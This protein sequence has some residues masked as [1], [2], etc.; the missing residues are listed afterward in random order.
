MASI[1][2]VRKDFRNEALRLI[3]AGDGSIQN[4][5]ETA[6][7]HFGHL[8]GYEVLI[9]T[10]LHNEVGNAMSHLRNDGCVETVGKQWKPVST[11]DDD[12]VGVIQVRRQKRVRGE[13]RAGMKLAH[14]R[15]DIDTASLYGAAIQ[16][17]GIVAAEQE[18]PHSQVESEVS[19]LEQ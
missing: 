16:S 7:K 4:L 1:R 11:L 19:L 18:S 9:K 2:R 10:F 17:L 12:D 15:G 6:G 13:L 5:V 14:D 3:K 8:V